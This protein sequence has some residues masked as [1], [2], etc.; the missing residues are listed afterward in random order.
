MFEEIFET[1][2]FQ[3]CRSICRANSHSNG[4]KR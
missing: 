2:H 3:T 1:C 4:K